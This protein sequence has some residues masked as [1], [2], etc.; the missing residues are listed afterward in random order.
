MASAFIL[1]AVVVVTVLGSVLQ[2]AV[3]VGLG[4]L[5]APLLALIAPGFVPGPLLASALLLSLLVVVRDRAELDLKGASWA[6]VGRVPGVL[7]GA[8]LLAVFATS[9]WLDVILGT[10]LLSSVLLA[11]GKGKLEVPPRRLWVIGAGVLS[12]TSGTAAGVGGPPVALVWSSLPA[13]RMR[14]TLA[15]YFL[16]GTTISIV[17]LLFTGGF[18]DARGLL[19][20][21]PSTAIGFACSGRVGERLD[22]DGV[23]FVVLV[24]SGAASSV[25]LLRGLFGL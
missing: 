25:L 21:L 11:A 17:V 19:W 16:A 2:G 20:M 1:C 13:K 15:A 24:L 8:S 22:G 5:A 4:I 9:S 7:L 23:R 14:S 3:G 10:L 12:G 18:G 6:L